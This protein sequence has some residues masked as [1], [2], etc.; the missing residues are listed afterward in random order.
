MTSWG[1]LLEEAQG[2]NVLLQHPWL[3]IPS[4]PVILV[5]IWYNFL[6]DALRDASD[7]YGG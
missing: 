4:I 1:V 6:G 3:L 5:V 2:I 7:P